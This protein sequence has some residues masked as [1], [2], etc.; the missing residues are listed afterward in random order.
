MTLHDPTLGE[1]LK[2]ARRAAGLTQEALA[3][4]AGL[5]ARLISDLERNVN[6]APR[7]GTL[8]LLVAA[9]SL[10][11]EERELFETAVA[12]EHP[13]ASAS[14]GHVVS[15]T[16]VRNPG[17]TPAAEWADAPR[18]VGRSREQSLVQR[19]IDGEG[20][21]LLVFAGEPGVG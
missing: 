14:Q 5:S 12:G 18:L 6:H 11:P 2:Y 9:L 21:R 3:A 4:R 10:S 19:H 13:E 7:P 1:L 16:A 17:R 8:Q 20:P 15:P